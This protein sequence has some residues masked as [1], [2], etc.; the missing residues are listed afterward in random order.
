MWVCCMYLKVDADR[1]WPS[2]S[3]LDRGLPWTVDR[4]VGPFG[5]AVL[6]CAVRAVGVGSVLS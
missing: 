5:R 2:L 6:S 4:G 1:G 3:S